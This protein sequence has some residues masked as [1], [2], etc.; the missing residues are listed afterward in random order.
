MPTIMPP[1]S[2]FSQFLVG[3]NGLD[4]L[5]Y[6]EWIFYPGMLFKSPHVWWRKGRLRNVDHEGLDIGLFRDVN[7]MIHELSPGTLIPVMY[8][9][10]TAGSERD[11]LGQSVYLRHDIRDGLGNALYSIYGHLE[12]DYSI[13]TE[14]EIRAGE[15][16]GKIADPLNRGKSIPPH[17]HITVTWISESLFGSKINW[18]TINDLKLCALLNPLDLMI[19]RY[20]IIDAGNI[21]NNLQK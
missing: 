13:S 10:E 16:I 14:K 3:C 6:R 20:S 17:V 9:G 5:G 19:C 11:Y 1:K 8:K 4:A 18:E 7:G 15:V 21:D 2:E 12:P